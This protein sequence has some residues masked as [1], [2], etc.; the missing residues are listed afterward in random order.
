M[1]STITLDTYKQQISSGDA[2]NLSDSFNG[3]VGDE[4]VPLVVQF[5]ERGLA[6]QFQDGLV[7]FLTGFVGNL[8]EN[9]QVTAETGEAVSYVGTSDD[10]V[11]LGRVKMN[12]PGTMFPQEGYFYGFLGLQ[13]ADG[14]RVTTFNVWFHVY[15]GNPDMFVN[16]APFRTELQKL[17]DA[18][19]LLINDADGDLNKW[20]QKLTDL[21]TALSAQ[22]VNTETLLTTLQAQI[23]QSN[24]F[25]QGQMDELI[26]TLSNFK[27]VG[28]NLIDKLNNEFNYR[29]INVE[30]YGAKGDGVT[31]DTAAIQK[32]I[33]ENPGK[34]VLLN[35]GAI[36]NI[37]KAIHFDQT[38]AFDGHLA[39]LNLTTDSDYALKIQTSSS[40]IRNII[41]SKNSNV[42][43]AGIY[44]WGNAHNIENIQS[45]NSIWT[46]FMHCVDVKE[47]HF[48]SIRVDNDV[49][50]NTGNVLQ[51]DHCLNNTLAD[52]YLG[53]ADNGIYLSDVPS[54]D[55]KYYNEGCT[56]SNIIIVNTNIAVNIGK[57]T[58]TSIS[59]CLFDF[60][61]N[62]GVQF[63]LGFSLSVIG[64]WIQVMQPTA[65][66]ICAANDTTT[67]GL[68]NIQGNTIT[69]QSTNASQAAVNINS[70]ATSATITGNTLLQIKGGAVRTKNSQVSDNVVENG[71]GFY[72]YNPIQNLRTFAATSTASKAFIVNSSLV[73]FSAVEL[74]TDN[75]VYAVG[76]TD[77][78]GQ[79][80]L[81]V[82]ANN[83]ITIASVTT[84]GTVTV[85]NSSG[86][87]TNVELLCEIFPKNHKNDMNIYVI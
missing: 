11:G 45:K 2:F 72:G 32:A 49:K 42:T 35:A 23:K 17:L 6:Q 8:D 51:L 53:Y 57:C 54:D 28:A 83:G 66:A 41:L 82:V 14:K 84:D 64:C 44:V 71:V 81:H 7:P 65:V 73:K 55:G 34:T 9:D 59:N 16:K 86:D 31:D 1:I 20:K 47:S 85:K 52:S 77:A 30:W 5:K 3:R 40:N 36:Y 60:C 50:N 29:G 58:F 43:A 56:I 27:P 75:F 25:T 26:G 10:I 22:G 46:T 69:G 4:Q 18:V 12:L 21:F 74:G 62:A 38:T 78:N 70:A 37:S 87:Y 19:Q 67:F 79:T 80:H 76:N 15:N 63:N 33:D 68:I 61:Q 24:L 48:R 13:N 39:R